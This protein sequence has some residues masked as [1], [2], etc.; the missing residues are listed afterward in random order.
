MVA[1]EIIVMPIIQKPLGY[2]DQDL[3]GSCILFLTHVT[4]HFFGSIGPQT[5]M[6]ISLKFLLKFDME[7]DNLKKSDKY[8]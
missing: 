7:I 5:E 4:Y 2:E 8:L 3:K 6:I 1:P